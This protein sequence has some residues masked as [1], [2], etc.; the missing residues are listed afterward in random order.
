MA[1]SE[2]ERRNT[3]RKGLLQDILRFGIGTEF[4]PEG[5]ETAVDIILRR[6]TPAQ[7]TIDHGIRK[8]AKQRR[9][10]KI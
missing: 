4:T 5:F 9:G 7:K 1:Q 2:E 8:R 3:V 10:R 6:R